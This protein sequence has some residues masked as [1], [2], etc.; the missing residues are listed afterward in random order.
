MLRKLGRK[1]RSLR[2]LLNTPAGIREVL[3]F[4]VETERF[5]PI[6][7]DVTPALSD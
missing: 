5:K 4:T 3:K 2:H 6:F 1:A 7:G